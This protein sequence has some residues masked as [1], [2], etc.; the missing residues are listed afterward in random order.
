MI[1]NSSLFEKVLYYVNNIKYKL[2][3]KSYISNKILRKRIAEKFVINKFLMKWMDQIKD[4]PI[5][6]LDDMLTMY[7]L[8]ET[9]AIANNNKELL[10][11]YSIYIKALLDI[12]NYIIKE[13]N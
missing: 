10:E 9:N 4:D 3:I 2:P 12:K 1:M 5:D 7:Y 6:I 13:I 8:W 11:L